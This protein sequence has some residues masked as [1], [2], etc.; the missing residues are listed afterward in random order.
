M[1]VGV[2]VRAMLRELLDA[3]LDVTA[4]GLRLQRND[5]PQVREAGML[6]VRATGRWS[7]LLETAQSQLRGAETEKRLQLRLV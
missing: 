1:G 4:I 6:I 5:D 3:V 7:K 2:T